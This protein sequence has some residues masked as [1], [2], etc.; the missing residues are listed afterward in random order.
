MWLCNTFSPQ[1]WWKEGGVASPPFPL[2]PQTMHSSH[3]TAGNC[4]AQLLLYIISC[5]IIKT[6]NIK[7][8]KPFYQ[9]RIL[10]LKKIKCSSQFRL[11]NSPFLKYKRA[12]CI[13]FLRIWCTNSWESSGKT[14]SQDMCNGEVNRKP[15]FSSHIVQG[16]KTGKNRIN[17]EI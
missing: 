3:Y 14:F 16:K 6:L 11:C 5:Q 8:F 13:H 10:I 9:R 12:I 2:A 15:D 4:Q 1:E 7:S 17:S